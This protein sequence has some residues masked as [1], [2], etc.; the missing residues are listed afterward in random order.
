MSRIGKIARLPH[1]I[2]EQLNRRLLDGQS[3]TEIL[4]WVNELPQCRKTAPKTRSA[5]VLDCEFKHRPGACIPGMAARRT[6]YE[7]MSW[8]SWTKLE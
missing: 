6:R 3:G 4:Q 1:D 7:T 5:V 2:R 8:F